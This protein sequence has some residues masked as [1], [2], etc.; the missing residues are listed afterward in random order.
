MAA[1]PLSALDLPLKVIVWE[2]TTRDVT[3]SF[4]AA[5]Y[6][7]ERHSLPTELYANIAPAEKL[8]A[9]ALNS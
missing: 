2:S 5:Q 3:V 7:M 4:N 8:I 9:N 6:L 1:R